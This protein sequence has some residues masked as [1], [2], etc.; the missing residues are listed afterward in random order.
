MT[1]NSHEPNHR[2]LPL[3]LEPKPSP[4]PLVDVPQA[5][6]NLTAAE[7][8]AAKQ[9]ARLQQKLARSSAR[10]FIVQAL[11]KMEISG[12]GLTD[13]IE[14]FQTYWTGREIEDEV[15]RTPEFSFFQKIMGGVL[16]HQTIIDRKVDAVL[17]KGWPLKRIE[18]VLRAILRA[19]AYEM[20]YRRDVPAR[21]V[22]SE[23]VDVA[24]AFVEDDECGLVNGVLDAIAKAYRKKEFA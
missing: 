15:Y 21:V 20:M 17:V 1:T 9:D 2:P 16:A 7:N 13:A 19:G 8:E 24:A 22:M 12:A 5:P 18:A 14:E 10:L 23:Y 3:I 11:Y 6:V 4:A